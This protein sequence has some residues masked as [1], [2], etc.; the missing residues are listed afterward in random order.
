MGRGMRFGLVYPET[1][2]T[3][4]MFVQSGIN[5]TQGTIN[6]AVIWVIVTN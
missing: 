2:W 1:R 3:Y 4:E 6:P 5:K